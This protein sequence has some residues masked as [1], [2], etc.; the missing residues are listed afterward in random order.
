MKIRVESQETNPDLK[1]LSPPDSLLPDLHFTPNFSAFSP[2][3]CRGM[4]CSQFIKHCLC[5]SFFFILC[6]VSSMWSLLW[7]T[8]L[9]RVLQHG[10][11]HGV[12]LSG[13]DCCI[14]APFSLD[15]QV[16]PGACSIV[17]FLSGHSMPWA[18]I[19]ASVLAWKSPSEAAGG[20]VL[21]CGSPWTAGGQLPQHGLHRNLC[22]DIWITFSPS[23]LALVSVSAG[24]SV[25]LPYS[26][27]SF[28]NA[29]GVAQIHPSS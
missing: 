29:A 24:L 28:W 20:S 8:L 27:S 17:G 25:S 3:W 2:E 21:Y 13:A 19:H 12:S 16:L 14:W 7:R 15:P 23:S 5:C 22:F 4:G 1:R 10:S 18:S 26:H 11:F 9:H 6:L